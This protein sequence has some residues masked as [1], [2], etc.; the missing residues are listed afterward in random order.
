MASPPAAGSAEVQH[1]RHEQDAENLR[2]WLAMDSLE[3]MVSAK[4]CHEG[5]IKAHAEFVG[6]QDSPPVL[7]SRT[8]SAPAAAP[9]TLAAQHGEVS[10]IVQDLNKLQAV[11]NTNA[12]TVFE[13]LEALA[14]RWDA[15]DL[16]TAKSTATKK[17]EI[18]KTVAEELAKDVSTADK[19]KAADE[20]KKKIEPAASELAEIVAYE[21]AVLE[22]RSAIES[23]LER[24]DTYLAAHVVVSSFDA[25]AKQKLAAA[26]SEQLTQVAKEHNCRNNERLCLTTDGALL[27]SGVEPG[28]VGRLEAKSKVTVLVFADTSTGEGSGATVRDAIT[29]KMGEIERTSELTRPTSEE[30]GEGEEAGVD[31]CLKLSEKAGYVLVKSEVLTVPDGN[32]VRYGVVEFERKASDGKVE[33]KEAHR[34]RIEHGLYYVDAGL[35]V[36]FVPRGK[37]EVAATNRNGAQVVGVD[38]KLHVTGALAINVFPGGRRKDALSPFEDLRCDDRLP[39]RDWQKCRRRAVGR[40]FAEL[41]GIQLAADFNGD[42]TDQ[43][44]FGAVFEPLT[45]LTLSTGLALIEL[46][47]L[48]KGVI[49]GQLV[50]SD[51]DLEASSKHAPR[52]YGGFTLSYDLVR[53]IQN[54]RARF[55]EAK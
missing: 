45:G 55:K 42:L 44:Y 32:S 26:R 30:T 20:E 41:F 52:W 24:V 22:I 51:A 43:F 15:I 6:A 11:D 25:T 10:T 5:L 49:E 4:E 40:P 23:D 33:A 53:F 29:L 17:V 7:R 18:A 34:V 3:A 36:P 37:R 8:V 21:K 14:E 19:K 48:P 38:E 2:T 35:L 9:S 31:A 28:F 54:A 13:T 39:A 1:R 12:P 16:A 27:G 50:T 47:T 46:D